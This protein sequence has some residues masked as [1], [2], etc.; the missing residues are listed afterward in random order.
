MMNA[1]ELDRGF[2]QLRFSMEHHE[3]VSINTPRHNEACICFDRGLVWMCE[4][5]FL[6]AR[7]RHDCAI[8]T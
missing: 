6:A 5:F 7:V 4:E 2:Y 3:W 8:R 1:A